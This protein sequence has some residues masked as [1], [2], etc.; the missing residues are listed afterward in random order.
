VIEGTRPVAI[1]AG[2]AIRARSRTRVRPLS[3]ARNLSRAWRSRPSFANTEKG[4]PWRMPHGCDARFKDP[5]AY[6]NHGLGRN[7]GVPVGTLGSTEVDDVLID[8][9]DD[10]WKLV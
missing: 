1:G 5:V 8:V 9:V 10:M 6:V 2:V 3:S 4:S 7:I